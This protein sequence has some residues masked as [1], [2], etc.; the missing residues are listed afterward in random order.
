MMIPLEPTY[1]KGSVRCLRIRPKGRSAKQIFTGLV[2]TALFG[3]KKF[4]MIHWYILYSLFEKHLKKDKQSL[5]LLRILRT[6]TERSGIAWNQKLKPVKTI[7]QNV[8]GKEEAVKYCLK[9]AEDLGLK[10]PD[11]DPGVNNLIR[12]EPGFFTQRKPK[13]PNRVGVGYKDKGTLPKGPKEDTECSM[14]YL[15]QVGDLFA[16]LLS[17]TQETAIFASSY[18]PKKQSKLLTNF[19]NYLNSK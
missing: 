13:E 8:L 3:S 11:K 18:D 17:Q 6:T 14:D 19:K 7:V 2:W 15:V 9:I 12:V 16:D 5:A 10:L 1:G 4:T